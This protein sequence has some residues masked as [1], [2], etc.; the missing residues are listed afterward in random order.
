[1]P[2]TPLLLRSHGRSFAIGSFLGPGERRTVAAGLRRA[3]DAWRA[4]I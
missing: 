1:M 2:D 4:G 3:L